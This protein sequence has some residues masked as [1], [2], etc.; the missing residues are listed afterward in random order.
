ME[1]IQKYHNE[2]VNDVKKNE[3]IPMQ[4]L[5]TE[6]KFHKINWFYS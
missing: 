5:R 3:T 4:K 1:R 6:W 2:I